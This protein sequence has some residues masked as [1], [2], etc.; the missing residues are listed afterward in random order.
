[1]PPFDKKCPKCGTLFKFKTA[2]GYYCDRCESVIKSDK[3]QKIFK[4]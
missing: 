1:M 2:N 3:I 4:E